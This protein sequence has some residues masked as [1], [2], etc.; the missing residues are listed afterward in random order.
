MKRH[1]QKAHGKQYTNTFTLGNRLTSSS[2]ISDLVEEVELNPETS[3]SK[4]D[5]HLEEIT[6]TEDNSWLVMVPCIIF[7]TCHGHV[8]FKYS[9]STSKRLRKLN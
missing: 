2:H 1:L 9:T 7:S 5:D 4:T 6:E 3:G 8:H